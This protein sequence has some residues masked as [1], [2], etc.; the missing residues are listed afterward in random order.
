VARHGD[1]QLVRVL[2]AASALDIPRNYLSKILHA[3]AR[4]GLL[5]SS[6]GKS[7]GFRLARP[8]DQVTLWSVVQEFDRMPEQ[9]RCLLGRPV[10]SDR[11]ACAAHDAWKRTA[12]SVAAFFRGTTVAD[13]LKDVAADSR[14]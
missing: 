4:A 10:C 9:R 11:T 3:L 6:R 2:D 8:A 1:D 7:G 13:L 12:E 14:I 5:T